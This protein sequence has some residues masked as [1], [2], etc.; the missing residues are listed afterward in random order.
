MPTSPE[1]APWWTDQLVIIAKP[2][3][4]LAV[5]SATA[6]VPINVLAGSKWIMREAGSG[7]RSIFE[8][9]FRRQLSGFNIVA[10]LRHVPTIK[11]L[12]ASGDS[13]ACL[14]GITVAKEIAAGTLAAVSIRNM[15]LER[16]FFILQHKQ[17]YQSDIHAAL[18]RWVMQ[19]AAVMKPG[20]NDLSM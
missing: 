15:R 9:A 6:P 4:P 2:D 13:L 20:G 1:Y 19:Q 16:Q 5:Q 18:V 8:H 17:V 7:T 11:A 12:V 10:E 14:S 3:H